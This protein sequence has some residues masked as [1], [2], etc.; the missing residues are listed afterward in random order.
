MEY[1]YRVRKVNRHYY[2]DFQVRISESGFFSQDSL[3]TFNTFTVNLDNYKSTHNLHTTGLDCY[4]LIAGVSVAGFTSIDEFNGWHPFV[5][6]GDK[7]YFLIDFP[8]NFG[9]ISRRGSFLK[10]G[11][12]H[13]RA[14]FLFKDFYA[15]FAGNGI[16]IL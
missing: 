2:L 12:Y 13:L 8:T 3:D 11:D 10:T 6:T 7:S 9:Y 16:L 5:F 15:F 1:F 14:N 4:G